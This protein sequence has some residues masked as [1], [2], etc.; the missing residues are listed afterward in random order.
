MRRAQENGQYEFPKPKT[1][2]LGTPADSKNFTYT[3]QGGSGNGA[4][5]R[6]QSSNIDRRAN[7]LINAS[8]LS[9]NPINHAVTEGSNWSRCAKV[10]AISKETHA[11]RFNAPNYSTEFV[12]KIKNNAANFHRSKGACSEL[13]HIQKSYGLQPMFRKFK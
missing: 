2:R 11:G 4:E 1:R 13:C 6:T 5:N 7:S 9:Y 12:D 3:Y 10:G 8:K